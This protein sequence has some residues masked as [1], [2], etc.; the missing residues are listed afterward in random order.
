MDAYPPNTTGMEDAHYHAGI[1]ILKRLVN[2]VDDSDEINH[3][4]ATVK[5]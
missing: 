4:E 2:L 1:D 3:I 5:A